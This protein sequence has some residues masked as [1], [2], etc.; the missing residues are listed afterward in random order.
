MKI[1][2]FPGHMTKA[3]R[4]MEAEIKNIDCVIYVLDSRA[5]F[6]CLNPEFDK[7]IS[8][9]P[10][11]VVLNKIDIA[12]KELI[13]EIKPRIKD[14][15]K[16]N[17]VIITLNSTASGALP[18]I[19]SKIEQLCKAKIDR[20]TA[21]GI[22]TFIKAMVIGV[23]NTGKSTLVNNLCGKAKTITGNR[24]GVT[25]G[26]Q[27]VSVSKNIQI[28][29]TAG[30]LYPNIQNEKT[31]RYLAYIG[32]IKDDVL[33]LNDL[34]VSFLRDI[35][36]VNPEFIKNRYGV[37]TEGEIIEVL[38]RIAEAKKFMLKGGDIDYDRTCGMIIDDFR[39]TRLGE[40]TL[41]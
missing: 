17:C 13:N 6:A 15:F 21:K 20:N 16:N 38:E 14:Y 29:D 7:L 3:L 34:A 24:P 32:S 30:T 27:W 36:K 4:T 10:I 33:D 37:S 19:L 25:R 8:N 9:K 40:I 12:N 28:L 23:P 5:P 22:N 41:I 1:N 31:A 18:K 39:K 11:I 2:W 26:K 35:I